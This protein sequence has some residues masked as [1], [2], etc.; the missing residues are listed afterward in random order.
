MRWFYRV[1]AMHN[2]CIYI[3]RKCWL[4]GNK[5]VAKAVY[6]SGKVNSLSTFGSRWNLMKDWLRTSVR[7]IPEIYLIAFLDTGIKCN[8]TAERF[9]YSTHYSWDQRFWGWNNRLLVVIS[10]A[11]TWREYYY[12]PNTNA[13]RKKWCLIFV[14]HHRF[15]NKRTKK[16]SS[17][18]LTVIL[19]K[20]KIYD[21]YKYLNI[22]TNVKCILSY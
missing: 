15:Q 3:W 17:F 7:F 14:F 19:M 4:S 22:L 13:T 10:F 5:L 2:T 21:H 18:A 9:F 8:R 11:I 12:L 1:Y 16:K 6:Q 20:T